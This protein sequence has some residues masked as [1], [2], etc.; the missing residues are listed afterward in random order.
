M[1]GLAPED[2]ESDRVGDV[3]VGHLPCVRT[4]AFRQPK[5]GRGGRK[6]LRH[7]P[8]VV[9]PSLV[10]IGFR[11]FSGTS[12]GARLWITMRITYITICY[13]SRFYARRKP[14]PAK[15]C[16]FAAVR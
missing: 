9:E 3:F 7:R 10:A 16:H 12:R 6:P 15:S 5:N 2:D 4:A 1:Q 8:G 13:K 14:P 11:P